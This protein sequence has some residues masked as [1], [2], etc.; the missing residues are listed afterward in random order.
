M[1]FILEFISAKIISISFKTYKPLEVITISILLRSYEDTLLFTK[2]LEINLSTNL[3]TLEDLS[4]IRFSIFIK[5][6]DSP[7]CSFKIRNTL[8]C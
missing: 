8:Y 3:D 7:F 5:A 6:V 1:A 2:F 4:N